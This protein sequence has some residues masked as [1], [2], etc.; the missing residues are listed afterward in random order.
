VDCSNIFKENAVFCL[1]SPLAQIIYVQQA[2]TDNLFLHEEDETR[3]KQIIKATLVV[4]KCI[5]SHSR[6]T[7][8]PEW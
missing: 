6:K 2:R 8:L 7:L 3:K 4:L 1:S 5:V